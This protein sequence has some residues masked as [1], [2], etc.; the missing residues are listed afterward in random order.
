MKLGSVYNHIRINSLRPRLPRRRNGG[1][2]IQTNKSSHALCSV[3]DD[4][5]LR[6]SGDRSF[7]VFFVFGDFLF[8]LSERRRP[9]QPSAVAIC[10]VSPVI[11]FLLC[12]VC[13]QWKEKSG[14]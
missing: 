12:F 1:L 7:F 2:E 5:F 8:L 9:Q 13:F 11:Y 6:T 10:Y 14:E 3:A 4:Y